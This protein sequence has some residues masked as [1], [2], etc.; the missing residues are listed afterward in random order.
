METNGSI[1]GKY[2]Q[3]QASVQAVAKLENINLT[4][5]SHMIQKKLS[6]MTD[7]AMTDNTETREFVSPGEFVRLRGANETWQAI[8]NDFYMPCMCICCN[9]TLFCIQ[10][11]ICVICPACRIVSPLEGVVYDGYDGGVGL[12]FTIEELSKWQQ[13]ITMERETDTSVKFVSKYARG[14]RL[15]S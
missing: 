5:K 4:S 14:E 2:Q 3:L 9:L 6:S 12:G 11:A 7:T 15:K 10:D 1:R 13:E 8:K